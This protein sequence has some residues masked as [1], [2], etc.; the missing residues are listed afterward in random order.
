MGIT[1]VETSRPIHNDQLPAPRAVAWHALTI[2]LVLW[3]PAL[4]PVGSALDDE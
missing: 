1:S 2:L 4:V 3:T